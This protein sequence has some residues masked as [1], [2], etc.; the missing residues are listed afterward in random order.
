MAVFGAPVAHEDDPE[1]AVRAALAIRDW[2]REDGSLEVRIAV[3]TGEALVSLDARPEAGE[4]MVAGDVVNTA[5]R[6]QAAAPVNGVLVGETTY[7]ATDRAIDYR[8]RRAVSA[9]GKAQPVAVWEAV[10]ARSR[11]GVDV[12]HD[13]RGPLVG[14]DDEL[15]ALVGALGRARRER[16]AHLVTL[17]GVPGIGKS[18]LVRELFRSLEHDPELVYW[19]QGRSLPYGEAVTF[20]ALAEIVKAHAGILET[21]CR[22]RGARKAAPRRHGDGGRR[23]RRDLDRR[24]PG[25]L[26]G[27]GEADPAGQERQEEAFAAWRAFFE[28]LADQRPFVLVFEDLHWAD[29]ASLD[30]VDYLADWAGDVPLLLAVHRAPRAAR[31][32]GRAGAAARRMRRRCTSGRS[33][34]TTP[35][36]CVSAALGQAAL[37]AETQAHLL[38][39]AGGNPLYAE[40]YVRMLIDRGYLRREG[41]AW[42]L[43]GSEE[44]PLP[45]SVQGII[46]ARLDALTSAEKALLQDASVVGKVFWV[47]P[48]ARGR[49]ARAARC[50]AAI[51]TRSP[52]R[53]SSVPSGAPRWRARRSTR[54]G[55]CSC[56][57]SP[58]ARSP[59]PTA[60]R[61][62]VP[63]PSGSRRSR[64]TAP[65]TERRC[66]P[67][68]TRRR[69]SSPRPRASAPARLPSER[70]T[71]SGTRPTARSRSARSH[72]RLRCTAERWT[73]GLPMTQSGRMSCSRSSVRATTPP[74]PASEELGLEAV[75]DALLD[76]G[77]SRLGGGGRGDGRRPRRRA[78]HCVREH[79][80]RALELVHGEPPSR[81]KAYVLVTAGY[82]GASRRDEAWAEW[83]REGL[84]MAEAL[85][86]D[87]LRAR[88][89]HDD[90]HGRRRASAARE[91]SRRAS[92]SPPRRTL[93]RRWG[94]CINLAARLQSLGDLARCFEVQD[95]AR[96]ACRAVRRA[97]LDVRH[98]DG[99]LLLEHYWRGRWDEAR[100][101]ADA[102]LAELDAG[103]THPVAEI[104]SPYVARTP[105]RRARRSRRAP[106]ADERALR[107]RA[108]ARER[109]GHRSSGR[110]A[111]TRASAS[112]AG[113]VDEADALLSE[114]FE[115]GFFNYEYAAPDLAI[116]ADALGRAGELVRAPRRHAA[117]RGGWT[118]PR[119]SRPPTTRRRRTSTRAIGSVP[120][121]MRRPPARRASSSLPAATV[122]RP[123]TS[124]GAR[125]RSGARSERRATSARA[126]RCSLP[127]R[128]G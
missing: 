15:A 10:E 18:R 36:V 68:T 88:A 117:A 119:P 41:R 71:H 108:P 61:S 121:E 19:R 104:A 54:S 42:R 57:T 103:V 82:F 77:R 102:V 6:M 116:V 1:R 9:K 50:R 125:S 74:R 30:F 13:D 4:G 26:V 44:A 95:E 127:R 94:S 7:R 123:T 62:T 40:E 118:L 27:T 37:P 11:F 24:A 45:E 51:C 120:D 60:R 113:R 49:R 126:K 31:R 110:S 105:P 92:R 66:W 21:R 81:A 85:G 73:S 29:D 34:T 52:A 56:A 122:P 87:D 91:R 111:A 124:C 64:P 33:P 90:R 58:T 109:L 2:A 47:E 106:T 8:E 65:P 46:A 84:A 16:S 114:A 43:E 72:R 99:E 97:A 22:G 23:R 100:A 63:S 32:A 38:A 98:L 12:A 48:P 39:R 20:S 79:A 76:A 96:R 86:F 83:V 5:A 128:D 14:R 80:E 28:A 89:L 3:N 17:V 69:S 93:P 115:L 101:A 25:P 53:S 59:A 70:V 67:T 78:T 107:R 55:T 75:R 35:R 112:L